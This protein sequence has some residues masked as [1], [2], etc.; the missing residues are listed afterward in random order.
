MALN[1]NATLGSP[2]GKGSIGGFGGP[3]TPSG[4]APGPLVDLSSSQPMRLFSDLQQ[5]LC[6]ARVRG[7]DNC[8]FSLENDRYSYDYSDCPCT[9]V[10][11]QVTVDRERLRDCGRKEVLDKQT[12]YSYVL[13]G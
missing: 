7:L 9:C 5:S 10:D 11:G 4:I 12:G 8:T 2:Y 3:S 13:E 1:G 6:L